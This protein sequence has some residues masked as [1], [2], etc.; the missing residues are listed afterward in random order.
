[1]MTSSN[2][3]REFPPAVKVYFTGDSSK[4]LTR[5][6]RDAKKYRISVSAL[7]FYALE[8]GLGFVEYHFEDLKKQGG[9]T[10][11]A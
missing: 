5:L 8:A 10:P 7:A 2:S 3:K 1:M 11:K 4:L 6:K 9:A